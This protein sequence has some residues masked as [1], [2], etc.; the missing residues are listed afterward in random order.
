VTDPRLR[1]GDLGEHDLARGVGE[2]WDVPLGQQ[3]PQHLVAGPLH[4]RH[5]GD[6]EA[7]VD[8]GAARVVDA[9]DDVLDAEGLARD[10]RGEDVGVV[11]AGDGGEG[12]GLSI[13]A[14]R[15]VSAIETDPMPVLALETCPAGGTT[16]RPDR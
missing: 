4:R 10:P 3:A 16:T 1:D 13:R 12:I 6:A 2:L 7:L 11:T 8:L 15:R 9:R 14:S 5:G